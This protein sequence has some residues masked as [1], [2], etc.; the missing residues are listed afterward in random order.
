M[1]NKNQ[2]YDHGH[3]L[4]VYRLYHDESGADRQDSFGHCMVV[5]Y[6]LFHLW[7]K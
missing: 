3:N 7:G 5:P 6:Y 1:E 2:N 4:N